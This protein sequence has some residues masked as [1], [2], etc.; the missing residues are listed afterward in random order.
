MA[1]YAAL[2]EPDIAKVVIKDA[3]ASLM[4]RDAPALLNAL[5][6]CDVPEVMK[7]L[8]PRLEALR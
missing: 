4:D 8:G 5:R 7:L 6:V 3:P 1:T 2:L